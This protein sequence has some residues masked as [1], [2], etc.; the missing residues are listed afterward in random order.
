MGILL[1]M[2]SIG[3]MQLGLT[4]HFFLTPLIS[5]S[6]LRWRTRLQATGYVRATVQVIME[7]L[8]IDYFHL[9]ICYFFFFVCLIFNLVFDNNRSCFISHGSN[10]SP[11]T[12]HFTIP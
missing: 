1:P 9:L 6:K 4:C 10:R 3:L 5:Q 2:V 12:P 7:L 8:K 11:I